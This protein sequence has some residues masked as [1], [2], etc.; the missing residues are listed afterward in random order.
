MTNQRLRTILALPALAALALL[1]ASCVEPGPAPA[2]EAEAR[3]YIFTQVHDTE[4]LAKMGVNEP[5]S[6]KLGVPV[7]IQIPAIP[8]VWTVEQSGGPQLEIVGR[9]LITNPA[10]FIEPCR[11]ALEKDPTLS[12][13]TSIFQ[14][15][16]ATVQAG[17]TEVR[18]SGTP[19][20]A[21]PPAESYSLRLKVTP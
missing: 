8:T 4:L 15:D 21:I 2:P 12:C 3:P 20:S 10:R 11:I 19:A 13:P 9:R 16:F 14:I 17:E 7:Q 6:V 5:Q 1:L 18:L